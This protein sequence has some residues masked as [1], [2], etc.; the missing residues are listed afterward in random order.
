MNSILTFLPIITLIFLLFSNLIY[1][2]NTMNG[3][4]QIALLVTAFLGS[5][6]A[7]KRGYNI[8]EIIFGVK[9]SIYSSINAI[10]I[11][12]IIG[13]LTSTWILSGVVP[14][15]IYYGIELINPEYFLFSTCIICAIVSISTGSSWT[16]AATIGIALMSIGEL[17]LIPRGLTAGAII[18]GA[19]FGDKMSPLSETTN[20]APSVSGSS[21][22]EHIKYM[23]YTTIPSIFIT[24][25][26]FFFIGINSNY[27][28]I[29]INETK[30]FLD[31]IESKFYVGWELF[32]LPLIIIVLIYN[33]ISA[34]I[35]LL[36]GLFTGLIIALLFQQELIKEINL[37][38]NA[39]TL[40]TLI[41]TIFIGTNIQ[42]EHDAVS[43]LLSK[44]GV[45]GM[46]WIVIL[47]ITAMIFGGVM[48][49]GGFLKR[50]TDLILS[51]SSSNLKLIQSTAGSCIFFNITTCDQYLAI[52][53]P[54]RMYK[55]I[56][57]DHKLHSTNLS[58][59]IEDTGT[60]TSVLVPWNSCAAYHAEILSINPLAY[61]PYCFFN[62]I[63]PF[64]TLLFAYFNIRIKKRNG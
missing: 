55:E 43:K 32:T 16:T 36:I 56:Y 10:T 12:L 24:L 29:S 34:R 7:L 57:Q 27:T 37:H 20:L 19:Y 40:S 41:E 4:N 33:G 52:V 14:A 59:T 53:I 60:V 17:L 39:T 15:M 1:F 50:I 35:T 51:K 63:S 13:G 42:I 9:T 45:L 46:V 5:L 22:M 3:P 48:H 61:L 2:E 6:I 11:L 58:R 26:C 38:T 8:K 28:D 64:M 23:T 30:S 18:S 44:S 62:I 49:A 25:I 47:V 21:L 31:A 54:G